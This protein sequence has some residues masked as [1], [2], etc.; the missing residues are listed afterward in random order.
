MSL[1]MKYRLLIIRLHIGMISRVILNV[2]GIIKDIK[3]VFIYFL[4]LRNLSNIRLS[5][6]LLIYPNIIIFLK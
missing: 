6:I 5:I 1:L 2:L 4:K 3:I